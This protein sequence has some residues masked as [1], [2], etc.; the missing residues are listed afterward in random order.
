MEKPAGVT[1]PETT[2]KIA[3]GAKVKAIMQNENL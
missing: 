1:T 2:V 3:I